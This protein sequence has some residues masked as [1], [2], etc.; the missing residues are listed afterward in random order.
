MKRIARTG[1]IEVRTRDMC[2]IEADEVEVD[3]EESGGV[4][5][6]PS[7]NDLIFDIRR[8]ED[9]EGDSRMIGS[10][11]RVEAFGFIAR[12]GPFARFVAAGCWDFL[13]VKGAAILRTC[14]KSYRI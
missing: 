2:K 10:G 7:R 12:E 4:Y 9:A 8:S 11:R 13:A 5:I 3:I 6:P 1:S 14:E